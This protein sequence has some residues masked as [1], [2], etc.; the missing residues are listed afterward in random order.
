[1]DNLWLII[2]IGVVCGVFGG[3]IW[4][5]VQARRTAPVLNPPKPDG[6]PPVAVMP[7]GPAAPV[8]AV[9]A[10]PTPQVP[11]MPPVHLFAPS[12]P[13]QPA[14]EEWDPAM[15]GLDSSPKPKPA[16][17]KAPVPNGVP[18]G[19]FLGTGRLEG[20]W[21][22]ISGMPPAQCPCGNHKNKKG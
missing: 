17:V 21:C 12:A 5:Y 16:A 10:A 14:L 22:F 2:T 11:T 8:P 13:V 9:L 6:P 20:P 19:T 7:A 3:A 15:F 4:A 18:A 1:M